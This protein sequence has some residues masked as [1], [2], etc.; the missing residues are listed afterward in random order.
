MLEWNTF[1]SLKVNCNFISRFIQYKTNKKLKEK[2]N[3]I[4]GNDFFSTS[5]FFSNFK[6][7]FDWYGKNMIYRYFFKLVFWYMYSH[8][9]VFFFGTTQFENHLFFYVIQILNLKIFHSIFFMDGQS[10]GYLYFWSSIFKG[11]Y[12]IS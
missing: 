3:S 6:K 8:E 10:G 4:F 5:F 7:K 11:Q 9:V 12:R 2:H 1:V